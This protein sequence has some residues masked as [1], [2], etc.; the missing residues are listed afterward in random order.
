MHPPI[1]PSKSATGPGLY[2]FQPNAVPG[3]E[4]FFFYHGFADLLRHMV[5]PNLEFRTPLS[6]LT[7]SALF[8]GNLVRSGTG[9][10]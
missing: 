3:G 4:I 8:A 7:W 2:F 5:C 10:S 6:I 1:P 9:Q